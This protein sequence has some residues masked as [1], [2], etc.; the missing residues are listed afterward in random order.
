MTMMEAIRKMIEGEE[1][2]LSAYDT[3]KELYYKETK[4]PEGGLTLADVFEKYEGQ[5]E[6]EG[7]IPKIQEWFYG[8]EMKAPW[9]ATA[10]CWGLAQLGLFR[11][12]IENKGNNDNVWELNKTLLRAV[13]IGK[14]LSIKNP[15]R[16][17]IVILCF[18]DE[19][20]STSSKHVTVYVEPYENDMF[21][22]IGGNQ[23]HRIQ[24]STYDN[25]D[26]TAI[27]RPNY[28]HNTRT[29]VS[30]LPNA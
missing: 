10:L 25:A 21:V 16:G 18:D 22:G 17:D 28:T 2:F 14:A 8:E 7:I 30:E 29:K 27:Y 4:G 12:T 24:K 5:K 19:F 9:C 6:W 20:S 15:R 11:Y 1:Q 13:N 3:L 23:S 26:I